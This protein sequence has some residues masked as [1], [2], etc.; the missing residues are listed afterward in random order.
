MQGAKKI[1]FTACHS[2]KLMLAFTSPD[3]ISTSSKNF[4]TSRIDFTVLLLFEFLKKHHLP[5]GQVKN[6]IHYSNSK[7]HQP[8]LSDSTFFAHWIG[9]RILSFT[10]QGN[11]VY[12]FK[13]SMSYAL[14]QFL[15]T[16]PVTLELYFLSP[17]IITYCPH[18]SVINWSNWNVSY[19]FLHPIL[20]RI[21]CLADWSFEIVFKL[22]LNAGEQRR[23]SS[24]EM[25]LYFFI[26]I[27]CTCISWLS[28]DLGKTGSNFFYYGVTRFPHRGMFHFHLENA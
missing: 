21:P 24:L 1:T 23:V 15:I 14:D 10:I 25:V 12:N 13:P 20:K 5:V 2:G 4:L 8:G 9:N 3:V 16:R 22:F 18:S 7:I 27:T 6:R 17:V 28:N 11:W 19:L 26:H